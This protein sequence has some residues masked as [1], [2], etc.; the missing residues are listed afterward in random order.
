MIDD[1]AAPPPPPPEAG[2]PDDGGD[3]GDGGDDGATASSDGGD[4]AS[5]GDAADAAEAAGGGLIPNPNT[6]WQS[7]NPP[8][9]GSWFIVDLGSVGS[10]HGVH[11]THGGGG[12]DTPASLTV[13]VSTNDVDYTDVVVLAPGATVMDLPFG[14]SA[15]FIRVVNVGTRAGGMWW[16]VTDFSLRP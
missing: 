13:S 7:G 9:N 1:M 8:L 3:G 6:Q 2:P 16:S 4:G 11:I 15:R 5:V 14:G 10:L 12:G